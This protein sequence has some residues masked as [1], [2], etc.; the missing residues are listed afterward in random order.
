MK[1]SPT[2][3]RELEQIAGREAINGNDEAVNLIEVVL[4][5]YAEEYQI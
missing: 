4:H 2:A 3:V 5:D 1:L